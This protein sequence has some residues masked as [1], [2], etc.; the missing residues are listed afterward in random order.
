MSTAIKER[1]ILFS[2]PM[3]RAILSGAKTQT[4]RIVKVSG[5]WAVEETEFAE[6]QLWPGYEDEN[7][8]WQWI[9]CPYGK[10]GG[11]LWVRETF[12]RS[13][14]NWLYAASSVVSDGPQGNVEEWDWDL[15]TPNRWRPSIHMPRW[16]SRLTLQITSVRVERLN[17]ISEEDAIA[18]GCEREFAADGSDYGAGLTTACEQFE[19]LWESINGNGSW[20]TNPWV[21]VVSFKRIEVN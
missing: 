20:A 16:A 19:R 3:V 10:P 6:S 8:E 5:S 14:N 12:A 18:E 11:R 21:W 7:G 9:D 1:P 4:R 2:G 13:R 15:S 17:E